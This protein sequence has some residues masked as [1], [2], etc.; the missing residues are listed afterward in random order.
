MRCDFCGREDPELQ[1]KDYLDVHLWRECPM[2]TNCDLC[3]QVIPVEQLNQHK[4][5]IC[6]KKAEVRMDPRC[7]QAIHI[8]KYNDHVEEMSCLPLQDPNV[9][10]RCPL[11]KEDIPPGPMGWKQHLI[12]DGCPNNERTY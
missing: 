12:S 9:A 10:N 8:S 6:T 1:N 5:E 11:C 4:L 3:N 2:L 7:G